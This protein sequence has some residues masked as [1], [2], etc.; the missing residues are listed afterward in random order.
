MP[1][2]RC[3]FVT[4]GWDL[5]RLF[6]Y[7]LFPCLFQFPV[8]LLEVERSPMAHLDLGTN[9][10]SNL[11]EEARSCLLRERVCPHNSRHSALTRTRCTVSGTL[12]LS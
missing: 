5:R 9:R 12:A 10:I 7:N 6:P 2:A 1:P 8:E 4:G 3:P 11:P